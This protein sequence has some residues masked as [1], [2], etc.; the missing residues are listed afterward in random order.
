MREG[1]HTQGQWLCMGAAG[2]RYAIFKRRL[3]V[4]EPLAQKTPFAQLLRMGLFRVCKMK[5]NT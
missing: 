3:S 4:N 1:S 5:T 2:T